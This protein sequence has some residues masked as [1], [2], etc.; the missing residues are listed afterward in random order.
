MSLKNLDFINLFINNSC[1]VPRTKLDN[2]LKAIINN[3][4]GKNTIISIKI[5][6]YLNQLR[7]IYYLQR[8]KYYN[9]AEFKRQNSKLFLFIYIYI[10]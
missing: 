4:K 5:V 7:I 3:Y 6:E 8:L 10:Y 2:I 9:I 1:L